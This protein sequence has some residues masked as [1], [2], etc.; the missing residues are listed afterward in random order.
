M[1]LSSSNRNIIDNNNFINNAYGLYISN[2][3]NNNITGNNFYND[4]MCSTLS[5]YSSNKNII[6][7]NIIFKCKGIE[8]SFSNDI[9]IAGNTVSQSLWGIN[10]WNV[11]YNKIFNN[12]FVDNLW[13][14]ICSG[15]YSYKDHR[16]NLNHHSKCYKLSNDNTQDIGTNRFSDD[17]GNNTI[18]HNNF[19]NNSQNVYDEFNNIWDNG[20]PSGGNFWDDY[21]G[22]DADGDGIGD[23]PYL[24]PGGDNMDRYPLGNFAPDKPII[25]GPTQGK[26]G[27]NYDY[28][29]LT[30]DPDEDDVW[31]HICWGDNEII[32]IYGPY[33]SGEEITLSYNW[34]DKGTYSI[35]CWARDIYDAIS[36]T[37]SFEVTIPRDKATSNMLFRLSE[38]FPLLERLLLFIK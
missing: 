5:L 34:T 32:Y 33:P 27:I 2:S 7:N 16:I 25:S 6:K 1:R 22:T 38:K 13:Y 3:S 19:I 35:T 15:S 17:Y 30:T 24:I 21:N 8:I 36:N 23:T 37:T 4:A 11:S 29:F 14:G 28:T 18:Y 20:Y 31:Y 12:N 9:T 26:P 10:L